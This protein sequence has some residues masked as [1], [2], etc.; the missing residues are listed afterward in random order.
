ML[1]RQLSPCVARL[2][3]SSP[4]WW[5]ECGLHEGAPRRRPVAT[6]MVSLSVHRPRDVMGKAFSQALDSLAVEASRR[7]HDLGSGAFCSRESARAD[8]LRV[9]QA[10]CRC[11]SMPSEALDC[12]L[13]TTENWRHPRWGVGSLEGG[14]ERCG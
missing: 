3:T 7:A 12:G 10:F 8:A 6:L 11:W 14:L 2:S 13:R 4:H 9:S 5:Q 1:H